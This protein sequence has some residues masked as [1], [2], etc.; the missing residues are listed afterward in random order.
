MFCEGIQ[1]ELRTPEACNDRER[2]GG[3]SM[4]QG[5][6]VSYSCDIGF[7]SATAVLGS[8]ASQ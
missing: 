3:M 6:E 5:S 1:N 4:S 8:H 2:G 7:P